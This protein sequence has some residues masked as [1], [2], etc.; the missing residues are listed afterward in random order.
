LRA[1]MARRCRTLFLAH[2]LMDVSTPQ[3]REAFLSRVKAR[4]AKF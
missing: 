3:S 4:L 1:L 2:Y